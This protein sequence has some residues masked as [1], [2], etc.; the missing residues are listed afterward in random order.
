MRCRRPLLLLYCLLAFF[1]LHCARSSESHTD[2]R[3]LIEA[4]PAHFDPRIGGD[5]ASIRLHQLLYNGLVVIDDQGLPAPSLAEHWEQEDDR[6]YL[7]KLRPGLRFHDG[8]PV[9][10]ADVAF[11]IDSVRNGEVVSTFKKD[12]ELIAASEII[13][14]LTIR[15]RLKQVFAP[16][17]TRLTL[18]ILPKDSPPDNRK[19][20]GTGP[21]MLKEY[22]W[23]D[24]IDLVANPDYFRGPPAISRVQL[25]IVPDE[26]S[27][28]LEI[29]K[30][31]ADLVYGDI[32]PDHIEQL[33]TDP[34]YQVFTGDSWKYDYIGF[35]LEDPILSDPRVREA[36]AYAIDREKII[37]HLLRGRARLATGMLSPGHWAYEGNVRKYRHDPHRAAKILDDAGYPDPDGNGPRPRIVLEYKT[38]NSELARRKA[39]VFQEQLRQVGIKI[40]IRTNEWATF[41][42]DIRKGRFQIYSLTWTGVDDPD[43][44]RFR[45]HSQSVPP[46]G[47]NRNRYRNPELDRLLE[48]GYQETDLDRRKRIYAQVQ[49]ILAVDLPEISL[50]HGEEIAVV[51][52]DLLGFRLSPSG[53]FRVLGELRWRER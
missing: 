35:N 47:A 21:Y 3:V 5:Q 34:R 17:L 51:K 19:P 27:R 50:W 4:D 22:R 53:D 1:L 52:R 12:L 6:T 20:V 11:T 30:G 7:F 32:S 10:A 38:S 39:A 41:F 2:L 43:L 48:E 23:G 29:R 15:F 46:N 31:T 25:R 24:R 37:S 14:P 45:F 8:R 44:Y 40:R 36:I 13:G 42:E 49:K 26:T 9:T 16:F 18:G 33:R 28:L